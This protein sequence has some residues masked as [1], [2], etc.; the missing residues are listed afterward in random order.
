MGVPLMGQE[1][2]KMGTGTES[3]A[4]MSVSAVMKSGQKGLPASSYFSG[5]HRQ[6]CIWRE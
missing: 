2:R 6:Y 1:E 3:E 5:I 4:S